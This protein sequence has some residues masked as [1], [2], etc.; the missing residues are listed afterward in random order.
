MKL[1]KKKRLAI[2][3]H[4]QFDASIQNWGASFSVNAL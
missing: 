3:I 1:N 4:K 2:E